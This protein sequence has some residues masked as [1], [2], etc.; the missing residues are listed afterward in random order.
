MGK[1]LMA[2]IFMNLK[3]IIW[4]SKKFSSNWL[5]FYSV[6]AQK[7]FSK[8]KC[9][10]TRAL[11]SSSIFL[12]N[13]PNCLFFV[14]VDYFNYSVKKSEKCIYIFWWSRSKDACTKDVVLKCIF[15]WSQ[16][17]KTHVQKTVLICIFWCSQSK[18]SCTSE[19]IFL[20]VSSDDAD[21]PK[22]ACQKT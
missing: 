5:N 21:V 13:K 9:K 12:L 6:G 4:T 19:D 15:W 1:Y 17:N 16:S 20:Y 7:Y 8:A 22:D 10:T 18:D 2:I 14:F 11:K 3:I